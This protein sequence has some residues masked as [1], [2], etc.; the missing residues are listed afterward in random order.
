MSKEFTLESLVEEIENEYAP[1]KFHAD[2]ETFILKSLL[3]V[4]KKVRDAVIE[5]LKALEA[6]ANSDEDKE[7]DEDEVLAGI[8]F[9]LKSVTADNK[10]SRLNEILGND[11]L[12]GMKLLEKW[13]AAT[14]P[15]EAKD[16]PTS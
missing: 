10:G 3:R 8:T 7:T 5:R 12:V 16:S 4:D 9:V 1:L 14:Q 11:I 6:T 13:T 2:G 15:G